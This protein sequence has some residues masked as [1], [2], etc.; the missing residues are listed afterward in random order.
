MKALII[1][2]IAL[3]ILGFL[4]YRYIIYPFAALI[5]KHDD[6]ELENYLDQ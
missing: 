3:L 1:I 6:A 5:K 2:L 4:A